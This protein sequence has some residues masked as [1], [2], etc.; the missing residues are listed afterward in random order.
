MIEENKIFNNVLLRR[1]K[2]AFYTPQVYSLKSDEICKEHLGQ[3]YRTTYTVWDCCCGSKSLT[4]DFNDWTNL[5]CSTIE[6]TEIDEF[7]GFNKEATSFVFDFLEGDLDTLPKSLLD[8]LK[9]N[10]PFLF[11]INPPYVSGAALTNVNTGATERSDRFLA[12]AEEAGFTNKNA[13]LYLQ[14]LERICYIKKHFNLTNIN[15][16]LF[17]P[18]P[19]I[20]GVK[21]KKF[22]DV[23]LTHFGFEDGYYFN[24]GEFND[25]STNWDISLTFWGKHNDLRNRFHYKHLVRKDGVLSVDSEKNFC[26]TDGL[27]SWKDWLKESDPKGPKKEAPS[28]SSGL[29][30]GSYKNAALGLIDNTF[31][32]LVDNPTS[33]NTTTSGNIFS[34]GFSASHGKYI[35]KDNVEKCAATLAIRSNQEEKDAILSPEETPAASKMKD[36]SLGYVVNSITELSDPV[37]TSAGYSNSHG[38]YITKDNAE[39]CAATFTTM[40]LT[41]R[42]DTLLSPEETD[43]AS[44]LKD[45]SIGYLVDHPLSDSYA[46]F[47]SGYSSSNEKY[48]TEE[49]TEKCAATLVVRHNQKEKDAIVAPSKEDYKLFNFMKDSMIFAIFDNRNN[50]TSLRGVYFLPKDE[51]NVVKSPNVKYVGNGWWNV[52]NPWYP[53]ATPNEENGNSFMYKWL[54]ENEQYISPIAKE[55]LDYGKKLFKEAKKYKVEF[56]KDHKNYQIMNYDCG[57]YQIKEVVKIYLPTEWKEFNKLFDKFRNFMA[58]KVDD[59]GFV[60][61]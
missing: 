2:G 14:F 13:N 51:A 53:L 54:L 40:N 26:N 21:Q 35:N 1:E 42:S 57:W 34:T 49:N 47:S 11:K 48:I 5:Y 19:F 15:I 23:F 16:L 36:G 12:E 7:K 56:D 37:I 44:K 22:R 58:Q 30:N 52:F 55:V 50:A 17:S 41:S 60:L 18:L 59:L 20:T 33:K 38:K 31:G 27:K 8:D 61:K 6:P 10:K 9:T 4:R 46:I 45:G 25:V 28:F 29:K 24:A 3:D 43:R 32:Y 39:K